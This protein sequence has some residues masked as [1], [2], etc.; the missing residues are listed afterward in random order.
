MGETDRGSVGSGQAAELYKA[1]RRRSSVRERMREKQRAAA[2]CSKVEALLMT[3]EAASNNLELV[4]HLVPD[5]LRESISDP[6]FVDLC[7]QKF[8]SLDKEERGD[9]TSDDLMPVIVELSRTQEESIAA[10]QCRKFADMFDSDQDG[11]I[12]VTE[13]TQ[14]VQFVTVAGWLETQEG[15]DMIQK[16]SLADKTFQ[17]FIHMIEVDKE[18][19]WSIIPFLPDWLVQHLTGKKFEDACHE[20]FDALDADR[21]GELEPMELLP[22]IQGICQTEEHALPMTEEKCWRF[23]SLFDTD[24]NGVIRRDEFIEFA[25]FLTVMN[26]LTNTEEGLTVEPPDHRNRALRAM[27]CMSAVLLLALANAAQAA[28][29]I[30]KVIS[31]LESMKESGLKEKQQEEVQYAAYHSWC[32]AEI[33]TKTREVGEGGEKVQLLQAG[34]ES[35]LSAAE[36]LA[37]QLAEKA[38]ELEKL[39]A[40]KKNASATRSSQAESYKTTHKDYTESIQAIM[41]ALRELKTKASAD[42]GSFLATKASRAAF[43]A[44]ARRGSEPEKSLDSLDFSSSRIEEM[45]TALK[46]KFREERAAA[47]KEELQLGHAHEKLLQELTLMISQGE[48]DQS[49]KSQSKAKAQ[50]AAGAQKAELADSESSVEE[51]QKYLQEVKVTCEQKAK[52]YEERMKLR[53]GETLAIT[54]ATELLSSQQVGATQ[55]RLSLQQRRTALVARRSHSASATDDEA[56]RRAAQYLQSQAVK[57]NSRVLSSIATRLSAD[58]MAKVRDMVKSLITKLQE[59][60]SEEM[61]HR[62]WCEKELGENKRARE[63]RGSS[64]ESLQAE[65]ETTESEVAKLAVEIQELASQL[66]ENKETLANQTETRKLEKDENTKTVDD[67]KTAQDAVAQALTVLKEYYSG[68]QLV[69]TTAGSSL[70]GKAPEIFEGS[71]S[72]QGSEAVVAMLEVVQADYAKLESTTAAQE[73]AAAKDFTQ[74]TADMAILEV[75]QKKDSEHKTAQKSDKEQSA[76]SKKVDLRSAQKELEAA[77]QYYEQLQDSCSATGSTAQE[78]AA[79]RAEEIQSLKVSKQAENLIS[80][81][82]KAESMFQLLEQEPD[83]LQEVLPQLPKPLYWG[84]TSLDFNKACLDGFQAAAGQDSDLSTTVPPGMLMSVIHQL[85]QEHPFNI[86]EEQCNYFISRWDKDLKNSVT[87][88]EFLL[89]ARYV[90][91]MGYLQHQAQ[92]QEGVVAD[93]LVGKEKVEMLLT[94]LKKGSSLVW[95]VLPFL[96]E[97]L[98][99]ELS[100]EDFEKMCLDYFTD[101]DKDASGTLEPV[102][103]LPVIQELAQ[104]RSFELTE[105][106]EHC[107]RF[108]EIFDVD[109]NGVIGQDE[110]VNFVRYM[111]IMSFMQTPEGQ[112]AKLEAEVDQSSTQVDGLLKQLARDRDSMFKI[113]GLLPEEV[114]AEL[115]SQRFVKEYTD[116]FKRLDK[117]G[118]GALEPAE[119]GAPIHGIVIF[120][121]MPSL[122]A[123]LF[124]IIVQLS[125]AKPFAVTLEQPARCQEFTSIFDLRGD[126]VLRQDEFLDFARMGH[127]QIDAAGEAMKVLQDSRRI[128]D[129]AGR[130]WP[131][132]LPIGGVSRTSWTHWS[133]IEQQCSRRAD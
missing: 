119:P 43:L 9:L 5:T 125:N 117:D 91:V 25:Q 60:S 69:Q 34:I 88:A 39:G 28:S 32:D 128:E 102:E 58:P 21:S 12:N 94:E 46:D 80:N 74:L 85:A 72:G 19:L 50:E 17:D 64:V 114:Y 20:Q 116:E 8:K 23:T 79:R 104:A 52:D 26:F 110:F 87:S 100:S 38:A 89:L 95:D 71:Y 86:S 24:G 108:V 123:R 14:M 96:P 36:T 67:A 1:K 112:L 41:G 81:S 44:L 93:A 118:S 29:V 70:K 55:G 78:R 83:V 59:E 97:D 13:F 40:Q 111:M 122:T 68:V 106:Q 2:G 37:A 132:G 105:E 53:D 73:A 16:A 7:V 33:A 51:L 49:A 22:V 57:F 120:S 115:V 133:E 99:A 6:T 62:Q 10:E 30:A 65:V 76:M 84:L 98:V 124:E 4:L 56:Q 15:K 75:Q 92:N 127:R 113:M 131:G 82:G 121:R 77:E 129:P 54:K 130:A 47:E 63:S 3:L 107:R 90:I 61:E 109:N 35:S 66:A 18:R 103:I 42:V 48:S 101:L 31:M 45:L 27:K 126:G 11:L